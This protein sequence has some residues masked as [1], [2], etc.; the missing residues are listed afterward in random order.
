MRSISVHNELTQ[1]WR[2]RGVEVEEDAEFAVLT[3]VISKGAF[4]V[5]PSQHKKLKGLNRQNLRDHMTNE[6]LVFTMLGELATTRIARRDDVQ[7]F[8]ENK[9][10]AQEGGDLAGDARRKFEE[11]TGAPVL[12]SR[13]FLEQPE[14]QNSLPL[15][16]DA[17]ESDEDGEDT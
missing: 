3:A 12:S 10:A 11:Q 16:K 15:S 4:G 5:T 13:N 6:E 1:E 2:Q 8:N 17:G 14:A 9:E 7:G